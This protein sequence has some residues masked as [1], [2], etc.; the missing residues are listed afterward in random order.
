MPAVDSLVRGVG[1][2]AIL[3]SGV[4]SAA[5]DSAEIMN[6]ARSPETVETPTNLNAMMGS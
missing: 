5:F 6:P 2:A 4:R 3:R 1:S